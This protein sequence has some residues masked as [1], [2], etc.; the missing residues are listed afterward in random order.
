MITQET[1][2]KLKVAREK[3]QALIK[4]GTV[5][6]TVYHNEL[7]DLHDLLDTTLDE[8]EGRNEMENVPDRIFLV[9]DEEVPEGCDFNELS[10]VCWSQERTSYRDIE[11]VKKE[12]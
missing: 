9:I 4:K 10:D 12:Y 1:Y 5:R 11:Y 8:F 6:R 3:L 7:E 2:E